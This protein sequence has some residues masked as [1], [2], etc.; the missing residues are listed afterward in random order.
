MEHFHQFLLKSFIRT[1]ISYRTN[2]PSLHC[3]VIYKD[4][5]KRNMGK[6]KWTFYAVAR[7]RQSGLYPT[8]NECKLQVDGYNGAKFKGFNSKEDAER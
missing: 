5:H 3:A 1:S 8:W 7:G 4:W 6:S 2:F